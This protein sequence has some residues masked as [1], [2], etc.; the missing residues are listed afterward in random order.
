MNCTSQTYL[1]EPPATLT[2]LRFYWSAF[3]I[4]MLAVGY[5]GQE[6]ELHSRKMR[7]VP[8]SST[9]NQEMALRWPQTQPGCTAVP[10][11]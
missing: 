4:L 7:E 6:T 8:G 5:F 10:H 1:V 11:Q 2:Q 3:K 9:L